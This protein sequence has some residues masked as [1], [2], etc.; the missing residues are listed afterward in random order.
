MV[1]H[2]AKVPAV[3]PHP[4]VGTLYEVLQLVSRFAAN[5][6]IWELPRHDSE[7]AAGAICALNG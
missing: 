7:T 1:E 3:E 6:A 4:A 2:F 5:A